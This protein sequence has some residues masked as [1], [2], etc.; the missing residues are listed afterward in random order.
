MSKRGAAPTPQTFIPNDN[1][2]LK[3]RIANEKSSHL[4]SCKHARSTS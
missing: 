2:E 4:R 3:R 1:S